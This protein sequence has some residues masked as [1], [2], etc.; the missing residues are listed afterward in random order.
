MTT[1]PAGNLTRPGSV[2][3]LIVAEIAKHRGVNLSFVEYLK[4]DTLIAILSLLVG[5]AWLSW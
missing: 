5:V 2:A 4:A 1:T 3:N